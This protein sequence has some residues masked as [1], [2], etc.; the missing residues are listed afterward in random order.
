MRPSLLSFYSMLSEVFSCETNDLYMLF[1]TGTP[2]LSC[3]RKGSSHL[4]PLPWEAGGKKCPSYRALS[5][6]RIL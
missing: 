6:I 1:F 3:G 4:C 2:T 5:S